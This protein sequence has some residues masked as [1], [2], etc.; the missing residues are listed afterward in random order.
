MAK[1][2]GFQT[3]PIHKTNI[4]PLRWFVN[5]VT[6]PISYYFF[7]KSI[8]VYLKYE[9][10]FEV[11]PEYKMPVKDFRKHKAYSAIHKI[12]DK[13]YKKWGTLYKI[14]FLDE[15]I[16]DMS[17]PGWD[18]YDEYGIPYWDYEWH[19]DPSTGDAWRIAKKIDTNRTA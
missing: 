6:H 8:A 19:E 15:I 4:L 13:P 16:K 3:T 11:Y 2:D 10:H 5:K 12:L 14:E 9:T 18:D 1:Y 7:G 17:G